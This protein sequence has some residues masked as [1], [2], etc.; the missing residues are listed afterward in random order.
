MLLA[1]WL[2]S[3]IFI[4]SG[5]LC[6]RQVRAFLFRKSIGLYPLIVI[7]P[8][9][10]RVSFVETIKK[11]PAWGYRIAAQCD[12]M[13]E[14][15]E[16]RLA[17]VIVH[18]AVS[19][20]L[21]LDP[22]IP[23]SQLGIIVDFATI[24]HVAVRYAADVVSAKRLA[25]SMLAG[26]PLILI[27]RTKLEGWGR[28]MKRIFDIGVSGFFLI[29]FAP[30][31]ALIAIAIKCD[32]PGP[33]IYKN[34]RVGTRGLFPTYKFRRMKIELCTGPGYDATGDAER[35]QQEL[36]KTNS[37]RRGPIFK[38]LNDPRMT[39][40][41]RF[42]ER[43]SLD[44]LPQFMNVLR[45]NMSLVGPRPHMPQEVAGYSKDHHQLFSVK[46]GIT[47]LAQ[48]SGRS[49]LDFDEEA[50]LDIVYAENWSLGLDL[51]ILFK[52]PWVIV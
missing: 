8:L 19:E 13:N 10:R 6:M 22:F 16:E 30:L 37:E 49:D 40:V 17:A 32:S 52:T 42:L 1:A 38:V 12:E 29:L 2:L 34:I 21:V 43:T 28:I 7:G 18:D 47:G 31:Y 15:E 4:I 14:Q 5:R 45:G 24:Q 20:I 35:L 50:R 11:N 46:P 36:I 39:R 51:I 9:E 44:E 27:K 23:R 41:G 33:V 26:I 3:I 25:I 48:I